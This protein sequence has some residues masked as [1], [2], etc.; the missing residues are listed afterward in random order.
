MLAGH[1]LAYSV[2]FLMVET[3]F[4]VFLRWRSVFSVMRPWCRSWRTLDSEIESWNT[5]LNI[6]ATAF[7]DVLVHRRKQAQT[8]ACISNV[9]RDV[10]FF[11]ACW[12]RL[13]MPSS[14]NR[15]IT[16]TTV[17][18][19]ISIILAVFAM[20][21]PRVS[22]HLMTCARRSSLMG[23]A[24]CL[25]R[26]AVASLGRPRLRFEGAV[27]LT[28]SGRSLVSCWGGVCSNR[29]SGCAPAAT[30]LRSAAPAAAMSAMHTASPTALTAC[31]KHVECVRVER[32]G[33]GE[34]VKT[35]LRELTPQAAAA[36]E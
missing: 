21:M 8:N 36:G 32:V 15:R 4:H 24:R 2:R 28:V 7:A 14:W 20:V 5:K 16:V 10:R 9:N 30:G 17:L 35:H 26:A 23:D 11:F 13:I 1:H 25:G 19:F 3:V 22:T 12:L 27:P 34:S 31:R 29:A 33:R 6:Q 18:Y